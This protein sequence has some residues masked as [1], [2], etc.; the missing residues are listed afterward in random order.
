MRLKAESN[1]IETFKSI[2]FIDNS[3]GLRVLSFE[4]PLAL[5]S[6]SNSIVLTEKYKVS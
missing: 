1:L 6:A 3:K 2:Q 5:T 4:N